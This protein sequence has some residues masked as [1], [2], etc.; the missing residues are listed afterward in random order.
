[1]KLKNDKFLSPGYLLATV[2]QAGWSSLPCLPHTNLGTVWNRAE[3]V[4]MC[5]APVKQVKAPQ[6]CSQSLS[7]LGSSFQRNHSQS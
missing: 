4:A 2:E 6:N 1:M 3:A 7:F 5:V